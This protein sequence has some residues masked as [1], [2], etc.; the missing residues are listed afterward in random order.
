M[1]C[2]QHVCVVLCFTVVTQPVQQVFLGER[3]G[4]AFFLLVTTK[5]YQNLAYEIKTQHRY[6]STAHHAKHSFHQHSYNHRKN[7]TQTSNVLTTMFTNPPPNPLDR[8]HGKA[9]PNLSQIFLC[10]APLS[11]IRLHCHQKQAIAHCC[12]TNKSMTR[13]FPGELCII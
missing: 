1:L 4:H 3:M 8:W 2:Y 5:S 11:S 13:Q 10:L 7:L 6:Y 12:G 9:C